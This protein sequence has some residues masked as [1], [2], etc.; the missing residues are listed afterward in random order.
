MK[1]DQ[2]RELAD[3]LECTYDEEGFPVGVP[4]NSDLAYVRERLYLWANELE[5]WANE[6]EREQPPLRS[7][8]KWRRYLSRGE[9][10][11]QEN[12]KREAWLW[13]YALEGGLSTA[14]SGPGKSKALTESERAVL[15]KLAK[16]YPL[17]ER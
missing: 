17:R 8:F 7:L 12:L 14:W 6:L 9:S 4:S 2:V 13:S 10:G 15:D 16:K 11:R 5:L 3:Y 1:A